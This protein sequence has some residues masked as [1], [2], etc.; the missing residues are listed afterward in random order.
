M[1]GK[2]QLPTIL[3]HKSIAHTTFS[4]CPSPWAVPAVA[5]QVSE[6]GKF[7]FNSS[8]SCS[9]SSTSCSS[10]SSSA[11][12]HSPPPSHAASVSVGSVSLVY[13]S[14]TTYSVKAN[15]SSS[16]LVIHISDKPVSAIDN[17]KGTAV[18]LQKF[19]NWEFKTTAVHVKPLEVE[20]VMHPLQNASSAQISF[21]KSSIKENG[22]DYRRGTISVILSEYSSEL[23]ASLEDALEGS[24]IIIVSKNVGKAL[25]VN[26]L[27]RF[28]SLH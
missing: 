19:K 17:I 6:A 26:G 9:F 16:I 12:A 21:L 22:Y 4:R 24:P 14:F 13:P 2:P 18:T 20:H 23:Y 27:R 5:A 3:S 11:S 10:A 8:C 28:D 25:L 15:A 7:L 1:S